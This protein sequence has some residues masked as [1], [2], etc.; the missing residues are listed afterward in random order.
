MRREIFI[1]LCFYCNATEPNP[2]YNATTIVD[3]NSQSIFSKLMCC[4]AKLQ[5]ED[6]VKLVVSEQPDFNAAS[7]SKACTEKY[8]SGRQSQ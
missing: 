5:T 8:G 3:T 7:T 6:K 1:L 4:K 2:V